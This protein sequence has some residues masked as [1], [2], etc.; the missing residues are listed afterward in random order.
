[1]FSIIKFLL[2]FSIAFLEASNSYSLICNDVHLPNLVR[3][4][5]YALQ[6][7]NNLILGKP[8]FSLKQESNGIRLYMEYGNQKLD[9]GSINQLSGETQAFH[10]GPVKEQI[11]IMKAGT[12]NQRS[13]EERINGRDRAGG[14][15][16]VSLSPIDSASFGDVLTVTKFSTKTLEVP[17]K[18]YAKILFLADIESVAIEKMDIISKMRRNINLAFIQLRIGSI[19]INGTWKTLL[20]QSALSN[21][22]VPTSNQ[23]LDILPTLPPTSPPALRLFLEKE[24]PPELNAVQSRLRN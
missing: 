4:N 22:S 21:L 19:E 6:T 7:Q 20:L 12:V 23:I 5:E 9:L 14:G 13:V 24:L 15:F 8:I 3:N 10:W 16:Y 2:F 11:Y 17:R 18:I 1:M